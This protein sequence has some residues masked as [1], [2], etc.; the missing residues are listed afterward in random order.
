MRFIKK[1]EVNNPYVA[2]EREL[3]IEIEREFDIEKVKKLK[4]E[5]E[6]I[7][8]KSR[9]YTQDIL[10]KLNRG[11][12]VIQESKDE[13]KYIPSIRKQYKELI[14]IYRQAI[15]LVEDIRKAKKE[16]REEIKS[17]SEENQKTLI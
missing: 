14:S 3:L 4:E 1:V 5:Y 7:Q 10:D 13:V 17:R 9:E 11:I 6:E 16:M 2:K 15:N 12:E 8:I